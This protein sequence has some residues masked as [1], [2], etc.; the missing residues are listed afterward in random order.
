MALVNTISDRRVLPAIANPAN[1]SKFRVAAAAVALA[2]A[3]LPGAA[4]AHPGGLAA[5]GCHN[6]RASATCHCHR[7]GA[8]RPGCMDGNGVGRDTGGSAGPGARRRTLPGVGELPAGTPPAPAEWIRIASWNLNLLHWRTGGA[9]WRGAVA[10][11]D[12]D[13]ETL[14][15]YARNLNADIIAFQEVNGP[16]AAARV[17]PA[18][19][20]SLHLS[21]RYDSRYDDIYNGFAV[22]KRRFDRVVKRD[23]QALGLGSGSRYELRW[24]VDLTVRRDGRSLRLLNVH[25]KSRCF[26]KSLENPRD[27]HCRKLARQL[28]PLESWIDARWRDGTPFVV[29]GDFNRAMDRHGP[30]DHLWGAIDDGDPPGLKLHRLPV[31]REPACWRGTSRHHRHPIDFFVF[32]ARAWRRVDAASFRQ[33]VWTTAD[34]D[35][36]RGLPSD[37]CPIAVDLF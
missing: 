25:L 14:A 6:H 12:E 27:R 19:D 13:Y 36:R 4:P 32:G 18:R 26:S 2:A 11:S 34:A 17:F 28:E 31:G 33:L 8:S 37:H 10:R 3:L 5:D 29:L 24:G 16:R 7:A 30:R 22:R 35:P 15:R 9:L 20:Y 23:H 21:G 1:A